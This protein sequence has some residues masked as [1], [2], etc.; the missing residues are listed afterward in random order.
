MRW[1]KG[2][3]NKNKTSENDWRRNVADT[4]VERLLKPAVD[5][6]SERAAFTYAEAEREFERNIWFAQFGI[7]YLPAVRTHTYDT[8]EMVSSQRG[9][10]YAKYA[11][12][13][14]IHCILSC[15]IFFHCFQTD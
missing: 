2:N 7:A 13:F 14:W 9:A 10:S 3:N 8:D 6:E 11:D 4:C 12:S 15:V 1:R 5:R